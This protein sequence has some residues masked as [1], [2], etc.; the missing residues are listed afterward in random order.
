MDVQW[1][2]IVFSAD[3]FDRLDHLAQKR[4]GD[5]VLAEEGTTFVISELTANNW[6]R[7]RKYTEQAK[8]ETFLYSVSSNLLEE[9]A[10]KRFGRVRPPEWLKREGELWVSLW[11]QI[12]LERKLTE[13]V[14]DRHCSDTL[15]D[16]VQLRTI[17][18]AIKARIPWCG[19]KD[20]PIS[21][22]QEFSDDETTLKDFIS[23]PQTLEE[24]LDTRQLQQ[25]LHLVAALVNGEEEA[26][27][28][29]ESFS[30]WQQVKAE[31]DLDAEER[32]L[33]KLYF[34][35]A[36]NFS[37]IAKMMNVPS[38]Q[39]GRQIKKILK[40]IEELLRKYNLLW[41]DFLSD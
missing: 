25:A 24:H 17:I 30:A 26:P 19:V 16:K 41:N 8:P 38:H 7:C 27:R 29:E 36:L 14:V 31:L 18:S 5:S 6:E 15:R 35:D 40:R 28:Q 20:A 3:F 34:N 11:K 2:S 33:L 1:S 21:M 32:L 13:S 4:F 10:R 23:D 39:P 12:C 37:T 9:F 22:D